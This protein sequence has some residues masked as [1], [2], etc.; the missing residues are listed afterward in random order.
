M[1]G[2]CEGKIGRVGVKELISMGVKEG[3]VVGVTGGF[4]GGCEKMGGWQE[5]AHSVS[6]KDVRGCI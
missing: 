2:G 4:F 5:G 1:S 6:R 3:C